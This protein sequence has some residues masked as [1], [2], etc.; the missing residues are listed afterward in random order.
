M[1][2]VNKCKSIRFDMV[3]VLSKQLT[4]G[5]SIYCSQYMQHGYFLLW[6]APKRYCGML[7]TTA[8][9]KVFFI[10]VCRFFSFFLIFF[11]FS[12]FL[13]FLAFVVSLFL[14]LFFL[15]PLSYLLPLY[16]LCV[17]LFLYIFVPHLFFFIFIKHMF[18]EPMAP[19]QF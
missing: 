2:D 8:N 16:C 9:L 15:L 4:R 13:F 6:R 14:N 7:Q 18:H 10:F 3:W 5:G 1:D 19:K 11:V 12:S 17:S